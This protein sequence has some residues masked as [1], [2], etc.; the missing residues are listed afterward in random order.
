MFPGDKDDCFDPAKINFLNGIYLADFLS[1][2]GIEVVYIKNA[3]TDRVELADALKD[4]PTAVIISLTFLNLDMVRKI[5]TFI[6]NIN[7]RTRII[8]LEV[9]PYCSISTK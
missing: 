8:L 3:L 5:S 4:D 6:R 9:T 2:H 7:P 1:R